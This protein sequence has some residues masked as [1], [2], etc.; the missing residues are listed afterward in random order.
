MSVQY[1]YPMKTLH[2]LIIGLVV[3]FSGI[4]FSNVYAQC[5]EGLGINCNGYPPPALTQINTD[6]LS[7][8]ISDKP[9]ITVIGVPNTSAQ[10]EIDDPSSNFIFTHDINLSSN[11]TAIYILDI[12]SYKPG[13]YSATATSSISKITTSFSIGII[14]SGGIP[15]EVFTD[16]NS[17]IPGD[18]VTILG[19]CHHPNTLIQL[20]LTDPNGISVKSVQTF[21][22]KTG[23]F[24][25][26]NFTIP[27]NAING[28][29][30]VHAT[31]GIAH[32]TLNFL[33]IS[34]NLRQ[35]PSV[36]SVPVMEENMTLSRHPAHV[37][38]MQDSPLKQFKSGIAANNIK[39]DNGLSLVIK[40]EDN[41]PACVKP[42]TAQKLTEGG[43][44]LT[45][46]TINGLKEI[47]GVGEKIDFMIDFQGLLHYCDYPHVLVLDSNQN[48]VWKSQDVNSMCV[49]AP[50][51]PLPY[52]NQ[53]FDLN[54]GYGGPIMINKAG[55]YTVK[56]SLYSSSVEKGFIVK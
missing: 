42:D 20:S 37:F 49:S 35:N 23:Y 5:I 18:N 32:A 51:S 56:V 43:W 52:V 30:Q 24:S 21:S 12:S 3:I 41:S 31:S 54:S 13:V 15:V 27:T 7:Y 19:T 33:V 40:A 44:A 25:S 46:L 45:R 38:S 16:K 9:V 10:L 55:N 17:Y 47:Y 36:Q 1:E 29:W 50:F 26:S 11:G 8:E 28:T 53:N 22:N 6:K 39:C 14:S 2:F 48:I 4:S 34:Q